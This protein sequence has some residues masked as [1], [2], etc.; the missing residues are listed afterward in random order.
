MA[1]NLQ[2]KRPQTED[3]VTSL[4]GAN[5]TPNPGAISED[6]MM[7]LRLVGPR[8]RKNVTEGY[9]SPPSSVGRA[10][11]EKAAT[12]GHLIF[13]SAN[14]TLRDVYTR[15]SPLANAPSQRK[16][17]RSVSEQE[18]PEGDNTPSELIPT[19]MPPP[20]EAAEVKPALAT[21]NIRPLRKTN[22][23]RVFLQTQSLPA[24]VF[25]LGGNTEDGAVVTSTA[26]APVAEED[27]WSFEGTGESTFQPVQLEN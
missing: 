9:M 11:F 15:S 2:S 21:R 23:G 13:R 10:P 14:D 19:E 20:S 25:R 7:R 5:A 24:G 18:R 22:S 12:T 8:V 26:V 1:S 4:P 16:R 17:A 6:L 27:D 3:M